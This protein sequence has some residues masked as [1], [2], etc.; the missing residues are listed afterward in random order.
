EQVVKVWDA[1]TGANLLTL[2]GQPGPVTSVAFS[3]DG[4]RVAASYRHSFGGRPGEVKV[5]DSTTGQE[6]LTL[7]GY[8]RWVM[9]VSFSPDGKRIV[10]S[11]EDA[12]VKV[13]D[14]V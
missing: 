2:T 10:S 6:L 4:K 3:P 9:S 8:S 14:A 7:R 5:W 13:W 12:T 1:S 11:D